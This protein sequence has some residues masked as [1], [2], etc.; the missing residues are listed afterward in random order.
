MSKQRSP[1]RDWN[2]IRNFSSACSSSDRAATILVERTTVAAI[3]AVRRP[4]ILDIVC[5]CSRMASSFRRAGAALIVDGKHKEQK[6]TKAP[7]VGS[8]INPAGVRPWAGGIHL[9]SVG[10]NELDAILGGGQPLGTCIVVRQDRWT[11]DLG[12]TLVRY[13]CAEVGSSALAPDETRHWRRCRCR[14]D[15]QTGN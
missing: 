9:T 14:L 1:I 15:R 3:K 6:S 4:T 2:F 7:S 8:G 13:W 5:C 11:R 12:L 10:L